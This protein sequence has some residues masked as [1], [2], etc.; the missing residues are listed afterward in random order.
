MHVTLCTEAEG[1]VPVARAVQISV[2]LL[3]AGFHT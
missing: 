3:T 2:T 1:L